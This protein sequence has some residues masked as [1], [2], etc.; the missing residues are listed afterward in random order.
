[1]SNTLSPILGIVKPLA[2]KHINEENISVLFNALTKDLPDDDD[3]KPVLLISRRKDG[4]VIGSSA[5]LDAS[6]TVT[7][8]YH[9]DK[10]ADLILKLLEKV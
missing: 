1:M 8:I 2:K 3:H 6:R 7:G 9:Q 4:S 10:L 5:S